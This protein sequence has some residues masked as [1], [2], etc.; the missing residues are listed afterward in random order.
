LC[1]TQE[2]DRIAVDMNDIEVRRLFPP[3]S[4]C[5]QRWG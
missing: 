5:K 3:G 1:L 4:V 2:R